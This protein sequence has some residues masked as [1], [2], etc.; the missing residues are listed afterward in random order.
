MAIQKSIA[1][2]N[3]FHFKIP[4]LQKITTNEVTL[5]IN[6]MY[7]WKD[8]R[9]VDEDNW[10][11]QSD[12]INYPMAPPLYGKIIAHEE[13]RKRQNMAGPP[14]RHHVIPSGPPLH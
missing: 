13:E 3:L 2:K 5:Q 6:A 8:S 7:R 12:Q 1:N 10:L 9:K 14:P 11:V 4:D